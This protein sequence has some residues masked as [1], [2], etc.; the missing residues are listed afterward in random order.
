MVWSCISRFAA[1][2]WA[3]ASTLQSAGCSHLFVLRPRDC[4]RARRLLSRTAPSS[5]A[6]ARNA[7][8]S[9]GPSSSGES[10]P[11]H[12]QVQD[13]IE[14]EF[15]KLKNTEVQFHSGPASSADGSVDAETAAAC[16][17]AVAEGRAPTV[18]ARHD[19][20]NARQL[21]RLRRKLFAPR[22]LRQYFPQEGVLRRE[23]VRKERKEEDLYLDLIVVAAIAALS[24]E[25]RHHFFEDGW[26]S[27]EN[28]IL[29]FGALYS[30]YVGVFY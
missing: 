25:L 20:V 16:A 12:S 3:A 18:C 4:A 29:L 22:W 15:G 24:H 21:R 28:F 7:M 27:V 13:H 14:E 1:R 9:A 2:H 17:T 10:G 26:A 8:A 5:A 11:G 23:A 19:R 6:S 30:R